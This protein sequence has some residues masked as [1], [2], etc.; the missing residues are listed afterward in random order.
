[1][2]NR[3]VAVEDAVRLILDQIDVDS[4]ALEQVAKRSAGEGVAVPEA[5]AQ[6]ATYVFYEEPANSVS[7]D[8]T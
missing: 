6:R 7:P 3:F 5:V 8:G 1:M 2:A 4:V